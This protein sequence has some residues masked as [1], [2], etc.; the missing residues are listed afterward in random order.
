MILILGFSHFIYFKKGL[1]GSYN[2]TFVFT[3]IRRI[4]DRLVLM[5]VNQ[6]A[7]MTTTVEW[8]LHIDNY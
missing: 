1:L 3:N 7:A 5:D 2:L 6:S 8:K 4:N